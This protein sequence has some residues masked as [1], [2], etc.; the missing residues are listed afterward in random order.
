MKLENKTAVCNFINEN[1][2]KTNS[3]YGHI[4]QFK[5]VKIPVYK[6]KFKKNLLSIFQ[7]FL[8]QKKSFGTKKVS[9]IDFSK[10]I[11]P[12]KWVTYEINN[13][14]KI[15]IPE[16]VFEYEYFWEVSLVDEFFKE[17]LQYGIRPI[18]IYDEIANIGGGPLVIDK[19]NQNIYTLGSGIWI[20][21]DYIK[22]FEFYKQGKNTVLD[23]SS[24]PNVNPR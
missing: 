24:P 10:F 18:S 19:E 12:D 5:T 2:K 17:D 20:K 11:P 9:S 13:A 1:R 21:Y 7:F 23:W 14:T 22:D 3:K 8:C 16:L 6:S 15:A 4:I